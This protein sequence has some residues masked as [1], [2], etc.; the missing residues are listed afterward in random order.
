M[1]THIPI[2]RCNVRNTVF[3]K[4]LHFI[5]LTNCYKIICKNFTLWSP[6]IASESHR[7]NREHLSHGLI[8]SKSDF[9]FTICDIVWRK[10]H[11][12]PLVAKRLFITSKKTPLRSW[13]VHFSQRSGRNYYFDVKVRNTP[14]TKT[15]I[16]LMQ[17]TIEKLKQKAEYYYRWGEKRR[18]I[19]KYCLKT[20]RRPAENIAPQTYLKSVWVPDAVL[21]CFIWLLWNIH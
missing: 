21:W 15:E 16:R 19:Y 2:I 18:F 3:T 5:H 14:K 11:F 1:L 17:I 9:F 8:V 20:E 4:R 7:R 13:R 10:K 6:Q 12:S